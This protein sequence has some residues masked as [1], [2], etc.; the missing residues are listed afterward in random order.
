MHFRGHTCDGAWID[1][2][3]PQLVYLMD[4]QVVD[5]RILRKET[6]PEHAATR[7]GDRAKE[8]GN[9]CRSQ[10]GLHAELLPC[11][12]LEVP[13]EDFDRADLKTGGARFAGKRPKL[14]EVEVLVETF[15]KL[16]RAPRWKLVRTDLGKN[17][18]VSKALNAEEDLIEDGIPWI[19]SGRVIP[20]VLQLLDGQRRVVAHQPL[21][22]KGRANRPTRRATQRDD[23]DV[24]R[25]MPQQPL[26][27]A[28]RE[29]SVAASALAGDGNPLF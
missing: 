28:R 2:N 19:P 10:K 29:G 6:I 12:E 13:A 11:E 27:D 8:F 18:Q 23:V 14:R 25:K 3:E 1:L 26:E 20:E 5:R 7:N 21:P 15:A 4:S 9:G 17:H 16:V 22:G 24:A